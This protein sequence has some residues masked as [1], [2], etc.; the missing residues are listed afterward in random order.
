MNFRNSRRRV[1]AA[2]CVGFLVLFIVSGATAGPD[3]VEPPLIV[4]AVSTANSTITIEGETYTVTPISSLMDEEG[5]RI[6]LG[7]IRGSGGPMG[8]HLVRVTLRGATRELATLVIV[9]M[10]MP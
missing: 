2:M 4:D 8:P 6:R 9:P 5:N 1:M 7:N 3:P 10:L